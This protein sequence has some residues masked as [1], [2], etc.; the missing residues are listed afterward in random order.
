[1]V[2]QKDGQS[3]AGNPDQQSL[4][5]SPT[6]AALQQRI[7]ALEAQGYCR[8]EQDET[9]NLEKA[10]KTGEAWLIGINALLLIV[11]V[12]IACIYF[13][14]LDQMRIATESTAVAS[15]TARDAFEA[16]DGEFQRTMRQM[17]YQTAAQFN[18]AKAAQGSVKT[19]QQQMRLDQR[20]WVGI[21]ML[22][23]H[24]DRIRVGDQA[25]VNIAFKN[26][27]RTPAR[28]LLA[29]VV[30]EPLV[31]GISP[32]FFYESEK[33]ARY[34]LLPPNGDD[35]ISLSIANN[36]A[37]GRDMPM[38]DG[39]L[40][41]LSSGRTIL[42]FHGQLSYTDIFDHLHWT[43]FCYFLRNIDTSPSFGACQEHNDAGDGKIPQYRQPKAPSLWPPS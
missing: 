23:V 31:P 4:A 29:T 37:T 38:D 43:T 10:I 32:K 16:S 8:Q 12:I 7:V 33:T 5:N 15:N 11:Q 18:S 1:M 24:P 39:V 34:G 9:K 2:D 42:Y 17:I 6:L 3:P 41:A 40:N 19:T 20:A 36:V 27:G 13:G 25:F 26:T 30:K 21:D 35:F 22:T 14:Q 28:N